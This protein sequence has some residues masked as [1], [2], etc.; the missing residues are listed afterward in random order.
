LG[1][2]SQKEQFMRER[3]ESSPTAIVGP[4]GELLTVIV[5]AE[6]RRLEA[7]LDALASL[8]FPVNPEITHGKLGAPVLVE[9]PAFE[10][11][12]PEVRDT[13]APLGIGPGAIVTRAVLMDD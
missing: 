11:R 12:I 9:F 3:S 5:S 6:P 2:I 8:S 7:L 4:E 10:I 1:P 13:L